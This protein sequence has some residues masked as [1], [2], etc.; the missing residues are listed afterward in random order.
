[1]WQGTNASSQLS[2][3]A[4]DQPGATRVCLEVDLPQSS[5]EMPAALANTYSSLVRDPG[6][7][8]PS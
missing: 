5:L 2:V 1:M 4:Q 3:R 8:A 6:P 7:E